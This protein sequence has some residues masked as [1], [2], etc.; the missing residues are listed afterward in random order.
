[1]SVVL[2]T[3]A[4]APKVSEEAQRLDEELNIN[5]E[6]EVNRKCDFVALQLL[7]DGQ[8]CGRRA[9]QQQERMAYFQLAFA[10]HAPTV[11]S[12]V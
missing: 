8:H 6:K 4:G 11:L 5:I 9:K 3:F 7:L 2:V 12:S 10:A 1:M